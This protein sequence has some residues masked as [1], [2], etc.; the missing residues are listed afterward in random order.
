MSLEK[1]Q[2]EL[3]IQGPFM[4]TSV[5]PSRCPE[6]IFPRL[7]GVDGRFLGGLRRFPGFESLG[8]NEGNSG[9]YFGDFHHATKNGVHSFISFGGSPVHL[10]WDGTDLGEVSSSSDITSVSN[11]GND[12][13]IFAEGNDPKRL[14]GA[15]LAVDLYSVGPPLLTGE[16]TAPTF[17]ARAV[18][19]G[20]LNH[21][22]LYR[23]AYRFYDSTRN[24]RCGLSAVWDMAASDIAASPTGVNHLVTINI[25]QG[26]PDASFDKVE[27]FR[28]PNLYNPLDPYQGAI[29]YLE[30]TYDYAAATLTVGAL[31]DS[32]LVLQRRYDPWAD[33]VMAAPKSGAGIFYQGS[34]FMGRDPDINSGVGVVWTNPYDES[35]E[36]FGSQYSYSGSSGDGKVQR[37]I[38]TED[39]LYG[40]TGTTI[41]FIRKSG[42]TVA[43]RTILRGIGIVYHKAAVAVGRTLY[44]MTAA[45][46]QIITAGQA[47]PVRAI[48][49]IIS[50]EWIKTSAAGGWGN[51]LYDVEM[52]YD[53]AMGC[54]FILNPTRKTM[55][56]LW[57]STQAVTLLEG[58]PFI[59]A[60]YGPDTDTSNESE[61][62]RAFFAVRD[63]TNAI[64]TPSVEA[65]DN[66][67]MTGGS[68]S[69]EASRKTIAT[70]DTGGATFAVSVVGAGKC[71]YCV[72][73]SHVGTW[74]YSDG[75][76]ISYVIPW[77]A[78]NID[79]VAGEVWVVD[80]I[81]FKV[82]FWPLSSPFNPVF[83]RKS[84]KDIGLKLESLWTGVSGVVPEFKVGVMRNANPDIT[85]LPALT[86]DLTPTGNPSDD[87]VP[88]VQ[89][90]ITLEPYVEQ[91]GTHC[92]F[93]LTG[94]LI[95]GTFTSSDKVST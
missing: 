30:G 39:G 3:L 90:G 10:Y 55:L 33:P 74:G 48:Q 73:G 65:S 6:G 41:Y 72:S 57:E 82:R 19:G 63:R 87:H 93:E 49:R 77:G 13:F 16:S 40:L 24:L 51:T 8:G 47:Q 60:T 81:L 67:Q 35:V 1:Y 69:Y 68:V 45:G 11:Y 92:H 80:P 83:G 23:V 18:S 58:C 50:D 62:I 84:V 42:G 59:H 25:T 89:D 44:I 14:T 43:I 29:F 70:N 37:F 31:S 94:L 38:E 28:S 75:S 85:V 61:A 27:V 64:V 15:G 32:A 34:I 46:L 76:N 52:A 7:V 79:L 9:P 26:Q 71:V 5:P 12:I 2:K 56:C 91:A 78:G 95:T 66:R 17:N 20:Y 54:I 88:L 86:A 53:S 4:D 36:E 22:G 21:R